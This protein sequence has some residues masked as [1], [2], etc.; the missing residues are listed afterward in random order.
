M[1]A[2]SLNIKTPEYSTERR[3]HERFSLRPGT[4]AGCSPNVGEIIDISLGGISFNYVEFGGN[5]SSPSSNFILCGADGCCL[6]DLSYSV[7]SDKVCHDSSALSH[8]V[9]KLRRVR[10]NDLTEDQM[11][12]LKDFIDM[13]RDN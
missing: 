2:E 4:F 8:I 10:F 12:M 5:S 7:V 13:N 1:L 11:L 3:R 6:D 9:T